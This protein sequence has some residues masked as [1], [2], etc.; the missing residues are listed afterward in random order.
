[1]K[2]MSIQATSPL[3]GE[4]CREPVER[5]RGEGDK[6]LPLPGEGQSEGEY[7]PFHAGEDRG[8]RNHPFPLV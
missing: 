5:G 3:R 1:M 7:R 4:R 2:T 8:E 6:S